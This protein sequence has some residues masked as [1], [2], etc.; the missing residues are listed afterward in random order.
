MSATA[1]ASKL[2]MDKFAKV[3]RLISPENRERAL[4]QKPGIL[5]D[6]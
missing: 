6:P 5:T 2:D 1:T 4:F 3:D